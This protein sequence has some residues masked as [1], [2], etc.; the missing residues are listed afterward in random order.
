MSPRSYNS[1]G[2]LE[3]QA[4]RVSRS[5]SSP[6]A[7]STALEGAEAPDRLRRPVE[8]W[9]GVDLSGVPVRTGGLPPDA[10]AGTDGTSILVRGGTRRAPGGLADGVLTHEL[11]H[12]AQQRAAA[13]PA[14]LRAPRGRLQLSS[15]FSSDPKGKKE[16]DKLKKG[17]PLTAAEASTALDGYEAAGAG[18]RDKLVDDFH[19]IGKADSAVR[20]LLEALT[21]DERTKRMD[22]IRDLLDR[23]Q[24]HASRAAFGGDDEA[25][26]KKQ[27]GWME[28]Q[29]QAEAKAAAEADAKAKGLPPPKVVAPAEVAKAHEKQ[30][31]KES[32]PPTPGNRWTALS[33]PDKTAWN[34]K[35][36]TAIKAIIAA[37]T[38]RAPHLKLVEA[39]IKWDP[40]TIEGYPNRIFSL[41]GRPFTVG[42]DFIDAATADPEYVLGSVFHEIYGH[43]E[44]GESNSY[45]WQ[46]YDKAVS[47]HFPS[48]AKPADR[49][50]EK[51]LF[52]YLGTEIYA[53]M[54][55]FEYT[56][57][58]SA[59]DAKK[60]IAGSDDPA[61]DIDDRVRKIRDNYEPSVAK[62]LV[63]GLFERFRVDP[64]IIP[65][66]LALYVTAV[67]KYFPK[68][69]TK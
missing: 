49:H 13:A 30:V 66:A 26:A 64:R 10:L 40:V 53:E 38:K 41:S 56:K 68:A 67:E 58:I 34:T 28:A 69:L 57:P 43:P 5:V 27:G 1:Y 19:A 6:D 32:L 55:E 31:A 22:I 59:A 60:G 35:A 8:E 65:K 47:K 46:I 12:V 9:A 52:D 50:A 20:R 4:E 16:L 39:D 15:C 54:R 51:L 63:I 36:A 24:A 48:Y 17:D 3:E 2:E 29:A 7:A 37:A 45:E 21:P 42:M 44:F 25:L 18:D 14:V 62:A 11:V 23:V 61:T 33:A